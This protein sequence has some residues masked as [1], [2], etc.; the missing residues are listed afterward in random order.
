[1]YRQ[2]TKGEVN[3]LP[4]NN[5]PAAYSKSFA[6]LWHQYITSAAFGWLIVSGK[7]DV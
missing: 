2:K 7:T 5:N 1:M 3:E 6:Y 4:K